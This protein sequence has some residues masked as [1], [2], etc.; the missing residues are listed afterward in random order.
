MVTLPN[1]MPCVTMWESPREEMRILR[2]GSNAMCTGKHYKIQ[3]LTFHT[4]DKCK[5]WVKSRNARFGL[6]DSRSSLLREQPDT[7]I[8]RITQRTLWLT[9]SQQAGTI[10][11][12]SQATSTNLR[13]VSSLVPHSLTHSFTHLLIH[14]SIWQL[15][16]YNFLWGV[17][18]CTL[19]LRWNWRGRNPTGRKKPRLT[20]SPSFGRLHFKIP[21][22]ERNLGGSFNTVTRSKNRCQTK[23]S[24]EW[25]LTEL[26]EGS[27]E[28]TI[29]KDT[30]LD[31]TNFIKNQEGEWKILLLLSW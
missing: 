26:W 30:K 25:K 7:Q 4:V 9:S 27:L 8:N 22:L 23:P 28:C 19:P 29:C 16:I 17:R 1:V 6:E 31:S 3:C 20:A 2:E 14:P 5:G 10:S 13:A 15:E 21:F 12:A 24:N 18:G 11:L